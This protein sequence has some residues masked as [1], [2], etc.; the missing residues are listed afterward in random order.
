MDKRYN[1][2]I[3]CAMG[4]SHQHPAQPPEAA[5]VII[6]DVVTPTGPLSEGAV[7][8]DGQGIISWI[9]PAKWAP[10]AAKL[11]DYSGRWVLP[12]GVDA[13]VHSSSHAVWTEGFARLTALAATGGVT[14]VIDM[15]YDD[16]EPVVSALDISRKVAGITSSA[17][18]DVALFGTVLKGHG[19]GN[20]ADLVAAGACG[21]KISTY[22]THPVRFPSIPDHQITRVLL[23]ASAAGVPVAVHAENDSMVRH[24]IGELKTAGRLDPLAHAHSRPPVSETT[25]VASLL[26]LAW[27]VNGRLHLVHL[28][29]PRSVELLSRHRAE[30]SQ[31]SCE[32]CIHY[33][34]LDESDLE[35]QGGFAKCNP[36]L[37]SS[38]DQQDLWRQLLAG[39][40]DFVTSD[41]APWPDALK[42]SPDIF[43]NKSGLPGVHLLMPLLFSS[44]VIARGLAIE[45][46]ARLT[47]S[48]PALAYGLYPRKGALAVGSDGD[49]T[50]IDQDSEWV[51]EPGLHDFATNTPYDAMRV[52]G[53]IAATFVRG[54]LVFDGVHVGTMQSGTFVRPLARAQRRSAL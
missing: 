46:F 31:V 11:F 1:I 8:I 26:E 41:H 7:A 2:S 36:P 15:P 27:A 13:H 35:R 48:G 38:T 32:T 42:S 12:G 54:N 40:I 6:G 25:A 52:R 50:V 30:G 45:E 10:R 23:A 43:E 16:P 9:G 22:E 49:V 33:L 37:R 21:I 24:L 39:E 3:D 53:R 34:V 14:T 18:V 19:G 4:S 28:S 29:S 44:G 20:I 5:V 51:V 17:H 47:S